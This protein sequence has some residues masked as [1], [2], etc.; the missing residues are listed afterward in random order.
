[1]KVSNVSFILLLLISSFAYSQTVTKSPIYETA[2]SGL[3]IKEITEDGII[4]FGYQNPKYKYTVDILSFSV[5]NKADA[6]NLMLEGL[7]V[8]EMEKTKK[9]QDITH[10][11]KGVNITRYGFKQKVI[12]YESLRL[13]KGQIKKIIKAL[14][15]YE[16]NGLRN[17]S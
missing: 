16:Y 6:I 2:N 7:K 1:M 5:S 4:W 13:N 12:Y 11:F 8:L 14:E 10:E 9:D 3:T 17:K 15:E